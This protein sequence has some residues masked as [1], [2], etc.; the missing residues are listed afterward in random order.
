MI[1]PLIGALIAFSGLGTVAWYYSLP[2]H[3][4]E[5]YDRKVAEYFKKRIEELGVGVTLDD[6]QASL[7]IKA[8]QQGV[9]EADVKRIIN[10]SREDAKRDIQ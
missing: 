10:E 8:S 2:E 9:S 3:K 5:E 6:N 1:I 4:R 7:K